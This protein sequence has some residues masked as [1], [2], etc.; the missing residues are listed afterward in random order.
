MLLDHRNRLKV[1]GKSF[2]I[3]IGAELVGIHRLGLNF[4]FR[5]RHFDGDSS[6][7][8]NG[9]NCGAKIW[10]LGLFPAD[11]TLKILHRL[12]KIPTMK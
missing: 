5:R 3:L 7:S 11:T 10:E 9:K 1:S 12:H 2:L 8:V 4:A 6:L